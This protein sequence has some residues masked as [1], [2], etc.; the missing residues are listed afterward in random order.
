MET[1]YLFLADGFEDIEAL[2]PVDVL[3]RGGLN[4]KSVS[5]N[6]QKLVESAHGVTVGCDSLFEDLSFTDASMLILPGGMPGAANLSQHEGLRKLILQFN[7]D[8]KPLAAICAAPMVYGMLGILKG[9]KATCYPGFEE[10]LKGAIYT[11]APV[12]QDDNFITGN[13]PGSAM[14]FA[15]TILEYFCGKDKVLELKA[16][17]MVE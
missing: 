14:L 9:K 4:V 2:T 1:I 13:G 6:G 7:A 3:R 5:I 11:A 10:Q 8:N 16:G 12:E 15:F 17:M